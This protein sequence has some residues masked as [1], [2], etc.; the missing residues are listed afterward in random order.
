MASMQ[1]ALALAVDLEHPY[2]HAFALHHAT[3]LDYWRHDFT[4][5]QAHAE[6]SHR[7]AAA[8]EY[9]IWSAL[10]LVFHGVARVADGDCD[11]GVVEM[12]E[13]F[14]R[15]EGLATPPIFWPALLEIRATTHAAAGNVD[16]ALILID[17]AWR[18][19][20][21][22]PVAAELSIAHGDIL[23]A[24]PDTDAGAVAHHYERAAEQS[25]QRSAR[26]LELRSLTRLAT[27]P[28]DT[29]IESTVL[30]RLRALYDTFTEGF[31]TPQLRAAAAVLAAD[32]IV[33]DGV[34]PGSQTG[35]PAPQR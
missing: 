17:Q 24:A 22:H 25:A 35:R 33:P 13:G 3:L 15:Y 20:G 28:G 8:H 31:T 11:Q 27:H 9:T 21:T 1:R 6:E 12:E 32:A 2:S 29:P 26:M 34:V 18:D 23:L 19:L 14:E 10:A 30:P 5:V 16:R 4:A 7:V